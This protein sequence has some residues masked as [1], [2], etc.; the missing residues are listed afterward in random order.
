VRRSLVTLVAV[1][2]TLTLVS[3]VV[4]AGSLAI[5]N[6]G[7]FWACY[8]G[9]GNVKL[10]DY[11]TTKTC[12]KTWL[13]PVSWSQ[14]GPQGLQGI[15]GL[16]GV[17]GLQGPKGDTGATGA[18]GLKGDQ[19]DAGSTGDPG[20]TGATGPTGQIGPKGDPGTQGK[21]GT[22]GLPGPAGKDGVSPTVAEEPA[23]VNCAFGGYAVT[24][25]TG[26]V[27]A[28]NGAPGAKGNNGDA[29]PF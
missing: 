1:F 18:K 27:Y 12:P 23:G 5:P 13:G 14:T 20:A 15:Q 29:G 3:G 4:L 24:D 9:G 17:Q 28:C 21:D 8:D 7:V 16:Q 11:A 19:G 2:A 6:G 25:A 26:T 22:D 10:I